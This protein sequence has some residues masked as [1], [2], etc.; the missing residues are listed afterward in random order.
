METKKQIINSKIGQNIHESVGFYGL[1]TLL[2]IVEIRNLKKKNPFCLLNQ[3]WQWTTNMPAQNRNSGWS[4]LV[5]NTYR[6]TWKP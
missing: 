2:I 5:V 6:P 4:G 1:V 3:Y